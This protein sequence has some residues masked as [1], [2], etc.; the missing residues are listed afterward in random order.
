MLKRYLAPLVASLVLC[1]CSGK[2]IDAGSTNTIASPAIEQDLLSRWNTV[3]AGVTVT[4]FGDFQWKKVDQFP[5]PT[6]KGGSS[7][8][9]QL[10]AGV[11]VAFFQN[12]DNFDFLAQNG[13][14]TLSLRYVFPSGQVGVETTF[15]QLTNDLAS[16]QWANIPTDTRQKLQAFGVRIQMAQ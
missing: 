8:A 9:Y 4:G 1:S 11:L 12:G 2:T 5:H 13:L 7:E 3:A 10:F 15:E 6:Y 14:F 16:N